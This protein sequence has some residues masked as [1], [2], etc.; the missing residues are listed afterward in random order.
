MLGGA[1][2]DSRTPEF[3]ITENG[4]LI[5]GRLRVAT[6][7]ERSLIEDILKEK[8]INQQWTGESQ[9]AGF[10][11]L[12]FLCNLQMGQVSYIFCPCQAF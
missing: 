12:H 6:R 4:V 1:K 3:D 5:V 8:K 7:F 10:K 11:T 9:E 2:L